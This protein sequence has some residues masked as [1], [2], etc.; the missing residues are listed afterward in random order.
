MVRKRAP[1]IDAQEPKPSRRRQRKAAPE[2]AQPNGMTTVPVDILP[3]GGIVS[4]PAAPVLALPVDPLSGE[5]YGTLAS[6]VDP[7]SWAWLVDD[8]VPFG[9]LTFVCGHPDA[10]KSCFLAWLISKAKRTVLLPGREDS[11]AL[12]LLPR[13]QAAGVDPARVVLLNDRRYTMPGDLALIARAVMATGAELLAFDPIDSHHTLESEND[14]GAVRQMLEDVNGLAV[15]TGAATVA[16]RHPGKARGNICPGSRQ[17]LAVPRV[18]L[19]LLGTGRTRRRPV[20]RVFKGPQKHRCGPRAYSLPAE[21]GACPRF[22]LGPNVCEAEAE[23]LADEDFVVQLEIDRALKMLPR[24]LG[25]E[26]QQSSVVKAVALA[27]GITERTLQLAAQR[28]GVKYRRHGSG[29]HHVCFWREADT[30]AGTGAERHT[31][32][33]NAPPRQYD[34]D[35]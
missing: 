7:E 18:V 3:D 14:G 4:E 23:L 35:E 5:Q 20:L 29:R 26:E 32:P 6:E 16:V 8:L 30:P 33:P 17:W 15:E 22:V 10:G 9:T 28:L 12:H 1:K 11:T 19:E 25:G 24:L 34:D 31:L 27:E 21:N 13:L 2:Q